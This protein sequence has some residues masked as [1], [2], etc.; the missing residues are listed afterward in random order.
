[1]L[2]TNGG[3]LQPAVLSAWSLRISGPAI[4]IV[5]VCLW[6]ART[7]IENL[8]ICLLSIALTKP[9]VIKVSQTFLVSS[10]KLRDPYHQLRA[11][12]THMPR[13]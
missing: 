4:V 13:A 7:C 11:N 10:V 9:S 6:I 2:D 5:W 1:M 8:S 3:G 12:I